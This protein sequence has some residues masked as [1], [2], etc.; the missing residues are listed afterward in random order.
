MNII[1][2][3]TLFSRGDQQAVVVMAGILSTV[4]PPLMISEYLRYVQG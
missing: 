3:Q 2:R 4:Y 1:F